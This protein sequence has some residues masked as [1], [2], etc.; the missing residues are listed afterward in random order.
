MVRRVA[1]TAESGALVE[2][3]RGATG[4]AVGEGLPLGGGRDGAYVSRAPAA[5]VHRAGAALGEARR[6]VSGAAELA[7]RGEHVAPELSV[8]VRAAE[9]PHRR[10]RDPREGTRP[11]VVRGGWSPPLGRPDTLLL[12]HSA[13]VLRRRSRDLDLDARREVERPQASPPLELDA[14]DRSQ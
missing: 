9:R 8:A 1:L 13:R 6:V 2:E 11:R 12:R 5:A 14:E 10:D 3:D 7:A 4:A